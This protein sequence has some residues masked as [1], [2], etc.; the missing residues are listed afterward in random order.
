VRTLKHIEPGTERERE[1]RAALSRVLRQRAPLDRF[2]RNHLARL[3][4][5]DGGSA[6]ELVLK[7][8]A[9]GHSADHLR[10]VHI[11]AGMADEVAAGAS[12]TAAV[13]SAMRLHGISIATAKRVWSEHGKPR[14]GGKT[15]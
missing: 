12:V 9:A 13:E 3:I 4:D 11:A 2:I 5:P 10:D 1:A 7:P 6:Q 8:R 15:I 14:L